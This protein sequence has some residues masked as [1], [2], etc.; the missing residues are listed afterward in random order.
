MHK[1]RLNIYIFY[2]ILSITMY[3]KTFHESDFL[4]IVSSLRQTYSTSRC[5]S[6]EGLSRMRR[7][8]KRI[9][10]INKLKTWIVFVLIDMSYILIVERFRG[11][12][13]TDRVK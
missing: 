12:E 10:Y 13:I 3:S 9:K 7:I 1:Y 8:A 4:D 2:D 11:A 6:E 5:T